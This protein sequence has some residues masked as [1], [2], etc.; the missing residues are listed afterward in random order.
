[1]KPHYRRIAF[2]SGAVRF[3][4]KDG[5]TF[6]EVEELTEKGKQNHIFQGRVSLLHC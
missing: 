6:E 3:H 4:V 2:S 5:W 1:M